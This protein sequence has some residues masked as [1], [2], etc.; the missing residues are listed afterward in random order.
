VKKRGQIPE[1]AGKFGMPEQPTIAIFAATQAQE[2]YLA[3]IVRLAGFGRGREGAVLTLGAEGAVLPPSPE[4]PVLRLGG[5]V[6]EGVRVIEGPAKAHIIIAAIR[7]AIQAGREMSAKIAI[8]AGELDIRDSLWSRGGETVRLTEKET[9]ILAYLRAAGDR[10]VSREELL[11][12]V[13]SYVADVETHTLETHIYRLRQK[14]EDDPSTP[15]ILITQGDG[16][17]LAQ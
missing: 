4:I 11:H 5:K 3:D 15:K 10:A 14:I 7:A 8:G 13:W 16:Y 9:A 17:V 6:E 1:I 2:A 12:H